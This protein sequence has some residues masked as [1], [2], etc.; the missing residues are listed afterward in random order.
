MFKISLAAFMACALAQMA[1]AQATAPEWGMCGGGGLQ[2]TGPT[3]CPPG[4]YCQVCTEFYSQ[5]LRVPTT[6]TSTIITLN[7]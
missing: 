7:C 3:T 2:W 5:C 6:A 1:V 4:W